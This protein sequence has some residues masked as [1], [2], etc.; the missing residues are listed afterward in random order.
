MRLSHEHSSAHRVPLALVDTVICAVIPAHVA[1]QRH[2]VVALVQ[3][4]HINVPLRLLVCVERDFVVQTAQAV[5]PQT[6]W[7]LA[8][9]I[10]EDLRVASRPP[11]DMD[12]VMGRKQCRICSCSMHGDACGIA[13]GGKRVSSVHAVQ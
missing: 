4:Q 10:E 11:A 7:R 9:R 12:T 1:R 2:P 5:A 3:Q 13:P 8:H 6:V